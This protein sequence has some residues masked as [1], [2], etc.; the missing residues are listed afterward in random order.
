MSRVLVVEHD[1]SVVALILPKL[2][3]LGHDPLV[4]ADARSALAQLADIPPELV[5]TAYGLPDVDGLRLVEEISQSFSRIPAVLMTERGNEDLATEALLRGAASYIPKRRLERDLGRTIQMLLGLSRAA[6]RNRHLL[7]S[8]RE[9]ADRFVIDNSP[10]LIPP[11][12][13]H[14][15][16]TL[17]LLQFGDDRARLRISVALTE[18]LEN[19]VFH[20]NLEL[21]SEL[22]AGDGARWNEESERRRRLPPYA[23]RTVDVRATLSRAEVRFTIRDEGPGFDP[24]SLPDPRSPE[25][26]ADIGGRGVLLIRTFMDRVEYSPR[27]NEVTLVKLAS[28]AADQ[29]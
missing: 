19:A 18:A 1:P 8:W 3:C 6:R 25:H 26:I 9:T 22:R 10:E 20:G 15:Q 24:A 28:A 14:V 27:G 5:L 7:T 4:V 2:T 11:L 21:S 23:H 16:E 13:H 29:S 12:V 17:Q